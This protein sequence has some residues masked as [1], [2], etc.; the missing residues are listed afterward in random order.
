MLKCQI[1]LNVSAD[2]IKRRATRAMGIF[3]STPTAQGAVR[4]ACLAL[5]SSLLDVPQDAALVGA[6]SLA[7]LEAGIEAHQQA[8]T[9][10]LPPALR[11]VFEGIRL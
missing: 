4:S 11:N 9:K 7:E 3:S 1:K 6:K 2:Q 8:M 5:R 10:A